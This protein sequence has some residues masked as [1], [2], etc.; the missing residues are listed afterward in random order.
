MSNN[1]RVKINIMDDGKRLDYYFI[2]NLAVLNVNASI[3]RNTSNFTRLRENIVEIL[4]VTDRINICNFA[5][6]C[7]KLNVDYGSESAL[8]LFN[9]ILDTI[10]SVSSMIK[11]YQNDVLNAG[12]IDARP[13]SSLIK[14]NE[15]NTIIWIHSIL[16]ECLSRLGYMDCQLCELLNFNDALK[17]IVPID[18]IGSMPIV[19][20]KNMINYEKM[21][22]MM[23][24]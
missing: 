2:E 6:L 9:K 5:T 23:G 8:S 10:K 18:M 14:R 11:F 1:L 20:T 19:C 16:P 22:R 3:P 13:I 12:D 17:S 4:E 24:C 15:D 21:R 7:Y